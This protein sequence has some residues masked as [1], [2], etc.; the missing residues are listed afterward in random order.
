M[1]L[2]KR[3]RVMSVSVLA[4]FQGKRSTRT[5]GGYCKTV[6]DRL[7]VSKGQAIPSILSMVAM[8]EYGN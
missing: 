8:E 3:V 7:Q 4:N 6:P 5:V 2:S 1:E